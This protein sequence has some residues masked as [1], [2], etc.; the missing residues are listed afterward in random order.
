[1]K[2]L[3][4]VVLSCLVILIF[5]GFTD[6]NPIWYWDWYRETIGG[7]LIEYPRVVL[8]MVLLAPIVGESLLLWDANEQRKLEPNL[9]T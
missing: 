4:F 9:V 2:D 8:A 1:M 6:L 7:F 3:V 5:I